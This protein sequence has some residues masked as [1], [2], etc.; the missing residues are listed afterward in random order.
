ME[1][2]D[3]WVELR[4]DRPSYLV[5]RGNYGDRIHDA[6]RISRQGVRWRFQRLMDMYISAF[7]TVVFIEKLFGPELREHAIS[8]SRERYELRQRMQEARF[9]SAGEVDAGDDAF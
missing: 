3:I 1:T 7:E 8:I 4:H 6:F 9:M 5:L 2:K